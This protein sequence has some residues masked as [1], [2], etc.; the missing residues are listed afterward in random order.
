MQRHTCAVRGDGER[1]SGKKRRA[2]DLGRWNAERNRIDFKF[3]TN[4]G[5]D[6][7]SFTV[8][9]KVDQITFD[10][11]IDDKYQA[12]HVKIGIN[13]K[14]PTE[15]PFALAT[16]PDTDKSSTE[17]PLTESP[18]ENDSSET[19]SDDAKDK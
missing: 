5:D 7:F 16:S 15:V 11:K 6:A 8:D 17:T 14:S 9:R 1:R 18:A 4:G 13:E 10:L 19:E 12:K 2:G 3:I